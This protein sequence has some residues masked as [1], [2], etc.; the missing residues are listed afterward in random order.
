MAT[1]SR[2][3]QV[4]GLSRKFAGHFWQL[5][6]EWKVQSRGLLKDFR[7]SARDSLAGRPSSHEKHLENFSKFCLWVFWRLDLATCWRL[8]SVAK[9]AC[10]AK[11]THFQ[12]FSQKGFLICLTCTL[13]LLIFWSYFH[14][15]IITVII[16][17]FFQQL[18][19]M[20]SIF[21]ER[22]GFCSLLFVLPFP[23]VFVF[24]LVFI[25]ILPVFDNLS[26]WCSHFCVV[27]IW[28][29]LLYSY[30][31]VIFVPHCYFLDISI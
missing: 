15:C 7:N 4:A 30:I 23:L 9:I 21:K 17:K 2:V 19:T 5:V 11:W 31:W 29:T 1:Q 14:L 27:L 13:C 3:S 22:Y 12:Q 10:S 25:F 18:V 8:T 20:P 28:P 16:F 6:R 26:V 24:S